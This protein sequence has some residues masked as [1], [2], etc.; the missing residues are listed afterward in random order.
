[1]GV[2]VVVGGPS[3]GPNYDPPPQ[4]SPTRGEGVASGIATPNL[5][6]LLNTLFEEIIQL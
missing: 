3:A 1:M 2:G 4:P 5:M 6:R